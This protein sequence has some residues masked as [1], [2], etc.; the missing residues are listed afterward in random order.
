MASP[1]SMRS[2]AGGHRPFSRRVYSI[3][4]P[5]TDISLAWLSEAC[6]RALGSYESL[7]PFMLDLLQ[8]EPNAATSPTFLSLQA[9]SQLVGISVGKVLAPQIIAAVLGVPVYNIRGALDMD[10][11]DFEPG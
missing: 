5:S 3:D 4:S 11:A 10:P 9:K 7:H 1:A 8:R 6:W 2:Y